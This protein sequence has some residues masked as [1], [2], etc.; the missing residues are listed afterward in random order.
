[1]FEHSQSRIP[2]WVA[3]WSLIV[4]IIVLLVTFVNYGM[5][6]LYP[7]PEYGDFCNE[8]RYA[9]EAPSHITTL[10]ACLEAG[11]QWQADKGLRPVADES[12]STTSGFCD[13]D[14]SC[15]NEY[16]ATR[17]LH[18]RN[19]L[20][21]MLIIGLIVSVVGFMRR[22]RDVIATSFAISGII[23]IIS[24][25]MR[26]WNTADDLAQFVLLGALLAAFVYLAMRQTET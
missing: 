17:D 12:V 19:G 14:F 1:M 7:A 20:I 4:G 2:H 8:D 13:Q 26:Y 24:G 21:A 3:D 5:S 18:D 15:R 16:E 25:L 22:R 23:I 11:G 10:E 9:V 6:F